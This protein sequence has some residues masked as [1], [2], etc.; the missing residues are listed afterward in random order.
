MTKLLFY[1]ALF[2]ALGAVAVRPFERFMVYPLDP[3]EVD[4]TGFNV[5]GLIANE[6]TAD[7]ETRLVIW[8]RNPDPGKPVIVYFHGNAS[9]LANRIHRF[10]L[11][12][13]QGYGLVALGY[14]GSSGSGG[15]ARQSLIE[16]DALVMYKALPDLVQITT[17][18]PVVLYGE[19][20]GAA[21]SIQLAKTIRQNNFRKPAALVLEAPFTALPHVVVHLYPWLKPITGIMVNKWPSEATIDQ[22]DSP[23]LILHGVN[24]Q[25]IPVQMGRDL[26]AASGADDKQMIEVAGAGH[27]DVWNNDVWATLTEYLDATR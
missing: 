25:L 10:D 1:S 17:D 22:I 23:L 4:P 3:T 26:L 15:K 21:V 27:N 9:N 11:F 13:T 5:P 12:A 18:T 16:A 2:L 24:D 14:R 6:L 8:T 7:D 19:S 20:I